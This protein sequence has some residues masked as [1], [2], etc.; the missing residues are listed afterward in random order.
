MKLQRNVVLGGTI[1]YS[2]VEM[3]NPSD[4]VMSFILVSCDGGITGEVYGWS[5]TG[6]SAIKQIYAALPEDEGY[7]DLDDAENGTAEGYYVM[8][9]RL[10][11][12]AEI[13][14]REASKRH[15]IE[16]LPCRVPR[17]PTQLVVQ[18]APRDYVDICIEQHEFFKLI[19]NAGDEISL[20]NL[21]S[22]NNY[23]PS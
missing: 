17:P 18:I 8:N 21:C 23:L 13:R 10:P 20:E 19:D 16:L 4:D 15:P 12:F 3:I 1:G 2:G 6:T 7:F 22:C 5:K 9:I 11:K 14:R